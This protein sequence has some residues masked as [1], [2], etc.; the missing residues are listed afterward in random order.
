MLF[1]FLLPLLQRSRLVEGA[2]QL[3]LKPLATAEGREALFVLL[4]VI[5]INNFC[6]KFLK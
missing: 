3:R 5:C 6:C 2:H 1:I 4:Q